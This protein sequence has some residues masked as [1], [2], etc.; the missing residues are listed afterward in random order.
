MVEN[1]ELSNNEY[2][3]EGDDDFE[4]YSYEKQEGFSNII[5]GLDI[6]NEMKKLTN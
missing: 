2:N 3:L 5:E 4:I 1:N 6:G